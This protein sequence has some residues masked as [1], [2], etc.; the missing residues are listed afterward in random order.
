MTRKGNQEKEQ[1][2][3]MVIIIIERKTG[4]KWKQRREIE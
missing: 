3:K 2:N 1:E 4:K